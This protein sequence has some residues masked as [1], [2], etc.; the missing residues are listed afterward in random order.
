MLLT[1]NRVIFNLFLS[2]T[3]IQLN[4][5]TLKATIDYI[6]YKYLSAADSYFPFFFENMEILECVFR[7]R[8]GNQIFVDINQKFK[9]KNIY[10][11]IK[12]HWMGMAL[13][14]AL[15]L[16]VPPYL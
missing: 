7:R 9:W 10:K 5:E 15:F 8:D 4:G 2:Y 13:Y 14:V 11:L 12:I 1:R 16:T 6:M 3:S